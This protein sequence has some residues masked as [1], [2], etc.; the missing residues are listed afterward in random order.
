MWF[1][2]TG[3][4]E[5]DGEENVGSY[6]FVPFCIDCLASQLCLAAHWLVRTGRVEE[7]LVSLAYLYWKADSVRG[8]VSA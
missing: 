3:P 8:L 5:E 2:A 1:E 4:L 7:A 6:R